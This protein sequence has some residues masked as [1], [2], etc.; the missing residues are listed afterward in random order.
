MNM[1][2]D[3][4][5]STRAGS[6]Q[7]HWALLKAARFHS[8]SLDSIAL[9]NQ[10]LDLWAVIETVVNISN[11]HTSDRINQICMIIVP[12]LKRSYLFSLFNELSIDIMNYCEK[13]YR[14]I[15][16]GTNGRLEE[17]QKIA[18]FVLLPSQEAERSAFLSS[19]SGFP[20]LKQ[21]IMHYNSLLSST[22][23]VLAF[24]DKHEN[25]VRWQVMRIYRNRNKIIHNAEKLPYLGLLVENLHTYVD[26]L[27]D[28]VIQTV[29]D[30]GTLET[31]RHELFIKECEWMSVFTRKK[32]PIDSKIITLML[33]L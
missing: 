28:Y 23:K 30:G 17:V 32:A 6:R 4:K 18:E 26:D 11:Q 9:E 15:T 8:I 20:L 16:Q 33:K 29:I 7:I 1:M 22:D 12:I 2:H 19:L 24:V 14:T 13:N 21:R 10:L 31:M 25:R 5:I 3:P 27:L